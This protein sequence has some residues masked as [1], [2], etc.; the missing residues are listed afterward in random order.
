MIA[1]IESKCPELTALCKKL[2]VAR[3]EVFGSAANG[4]FD[5]ARS[6]VDFLVS[7]ERCSPGEHYER[8]FGLLESLE[9][10]FG[11]HVDL[12]EAEAVCNPYFRHRINESR[13]LLYAA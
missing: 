7:F 3:L 12:V 1:Q 2:G 5:P 9:S 13:T 10:L 6:D 8:Y 11:R 4:E